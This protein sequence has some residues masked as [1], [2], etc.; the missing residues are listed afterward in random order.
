MLLPL[1]PLTKSTSM[2]GEHPMH[3]K[4]LQ[5][6]VLLLRTEVSDSVQTRMFL[7]TTLLDAMQ[8]HASCPHP[9]APPSRTGHSHNSCNHHIEH[10][11][12]HLYACCAVCWPLGGARRRL[13]SHLQGRRALR[14]ALPRAVLLPAGGSAPRPRLAHG[15]PQGVRPLGC[16]HG[17][18]A[19]PGAAGPAVCR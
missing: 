12:P 14:R 18:W 8:G 6:H 19:G 9:I 1:Y 2:Q 16:L 4:W 11:C 10:S 15:R 3:D 13:P 5:C 7:S 17:G